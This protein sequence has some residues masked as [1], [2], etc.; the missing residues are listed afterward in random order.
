MIE[1]WYC[2]EHYDTESIEVYDSGFNIY[3]CPHCGERDAI[4]IHASGFYIDKILRMKN[5][6]RLIL[7]AFYENERLSIDDFTC[8]GSSVK[9]LRELSWRNQTAQ[10][11][12]EPTVFI[13]A[14][15]D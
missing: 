6:T 10:N 1:C 14:L 9:S 7:D 13:E 12:F 4:P 3:R 11:G 5:T 8:A 15:K 2:G